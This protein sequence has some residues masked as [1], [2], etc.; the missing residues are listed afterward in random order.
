MKSGAVVVVD[1]L[2]LLFLQE[3]RCLSDGIDDACCVVYRWNWNSMNEFTWLGQ[4]RMGIPTKQE[5]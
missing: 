2:L 4:R 1:Q 3:N 5:E